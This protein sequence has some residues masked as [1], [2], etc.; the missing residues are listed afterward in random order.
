MTRPGVG[1]VPRRWK[2]G[3]VESGERDDDGLDCATITDG[4]PAYGGKL[5][6]EEVIA[7]STVAGTDTFLLIA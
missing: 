3:A 2:S 4:L 1:V 7:Y 5:F 6:E